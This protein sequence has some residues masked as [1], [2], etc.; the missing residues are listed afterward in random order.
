ML[1]SG[2]S[3]INTTQTYIDIHYRIHC[4]RCVVHVTRMT[5]DTETCIEHRGQ[6][7]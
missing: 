6:I 3:T 1:M 2:Q 7:I 4:M 5:S